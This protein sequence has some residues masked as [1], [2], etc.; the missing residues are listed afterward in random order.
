MIRTSFDLQNLLDEDLAWRRKELSIHK[1]LIET[2]K[3]S[4][5][6]NA[7][8][9]SGIPILYAHW[10]GYIKAISI[11]YL[12]FVSCQQEP[13][14]NLS[15]S[16]LLLAIKSVWDGT[17]TQNE[18]LRKTIHFIANSGDKRSN[19]P[20]KD[21]ISTRSNLNSTNLKDII[22]TL[23]LD[24]SEYEL[25]EKLI[26]EKLVKARHTIAHG[27]FRFLSGRGLKAN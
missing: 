16:F 17:A 1:T 13:H 12:E 2:S 11:G 27:F 24:Y 5:T 21:V 15:E 4:E 22:H 8:I 20:Y 14:K 25:K 3:A 10:E 18:N 23:G 7:A 6:L 26:D 19:L 9:R